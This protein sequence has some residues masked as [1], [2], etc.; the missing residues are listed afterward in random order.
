MERFQKKEHKKHLKSWT[1]WAVQ[2]SVM[3]F[4]L[5]SKRQKPFMQ[6]DGFHY[7]E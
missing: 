6:G 2:D 3:L 1:A 5:G 7:K 4:S